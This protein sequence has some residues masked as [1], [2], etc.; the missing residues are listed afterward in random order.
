MNGANDAETA[1]TPHFYRAEHGLYAPTGLARSPWD[2]S[3]QNGVG[4]GG[5]AALLIE[6]V[7]APV[8][9]TTARLTI[10]V[11]GAAPH[12]P[13]AARTRVVREGARQQLV[14]CE[15]LVEDR[16]VARASALRARVA[17]TPVYA[18]PQAYP[19]PEESPAVRFMDERAFG[20]TLETRLAKGRLGEPGAKALWVRFGHEHVAGIPLSPL[21]RCT[22]LADFGGG[23]ASMLT[24]AEWTSA[25]LDISV[26]LTREPEGEWLLCDAA[27]VSD[28]LGVARSD[29]ILADRRGP[30][31]RAHQIL[32]VAPVPPRG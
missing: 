15:L 23:L 8:P 31:A 32:F 7:P 5:L 3:K 30:F 24:R 25:N 28:G 12:A 14:D 21:L 22:S 17:E 1:L 16:P 9:M 29:M 27:T 11:L 10:D 13:I 2:K 26:H 20:G 18:E 6:Q 4:L 19:A